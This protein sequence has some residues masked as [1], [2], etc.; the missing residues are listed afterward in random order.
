MDI[1]EFNPS[2]Y[3]VIEKMGSG[4]YGSVF[5]VY[6]K[7]FPFICCSVYFNHVV[8]NCNQVKVKKTGELAALKTIEM[9]EGE[10]IEDALVEIQ[11]LRDCHSEF[12]T[13][14]LDCYRKGFDKLYVVMELCEVGSVMSIL[15]KLQM[16]GF[17]EPTIAYITYG[18]LKGLEYLHKSF[19][20]R[21]FHCFVLML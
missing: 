2:E 13:R 9:E 19:A 7:C 6:L 10:S 11:V 16:P 12:V 21:W 1:K 20:F 8:S 3:E 17:P 4:S 18:I 5:K 14:Y 15:Q